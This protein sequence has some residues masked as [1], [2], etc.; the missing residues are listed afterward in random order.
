LDH[1]VY[2]NGNN[3]PQGRAVDITIRNN[4]FYNTR[5]GWA[6]Q[7]YPGTLRNID[8]VNNTFA[9]GNPNKSY[10]YIVLDASLI[11]VTVRNNIFY[12][13]QAGKTMELGSGLSANNVLVSHNITSGNAMTDRTA[14][15]GMT[16]SNN[17]TS[18]NAM[19]VNPTA[20]DFHL[21]PGSPALDTGVALPE[22]VLD[23]DGRSRPQ[24]SGYDV[25]AFESPTGSA[26]F[27]RQLRLSDRPANE[28]VAAE[29]FRGMLASFQYSKGPEFKR[30]AP[31][32]Q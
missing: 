17:R 25:G 6:V 11:D 16:L 24:G 1:G 19:M 12:Q 18:T 30:S 21:L 7:M 28:S 10:T 22:V 4:V 29:P 14:P 9:F 8:V 26:Q 31:E 20:F 15:S 3:G 2:V 32:R 5:H 23:F 27:M 13:P